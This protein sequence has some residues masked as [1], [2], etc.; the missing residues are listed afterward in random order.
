MGDRVGLLALVA[1]GQLIQDAEPGGMTLVDARNEFNE[2]R[3]LAML[4]ISHIGGVA[5]T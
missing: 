3:H 2:L 5:S 4:W 1:T